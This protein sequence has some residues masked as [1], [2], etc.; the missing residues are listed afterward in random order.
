MKSSGQRQ[1]EKWVME[2]LVNQGY[3]A[4]PLH[5]DPPDLIVNR[6]IAVEVRRLNQHYFN[7]GMHQGIKDAN[8]SFYELFQKIILEFPNPDHL[9]SAMISYVMHRPLL[10]AKENKNQIRKTLTE[11]LP[12]IDQSR[13]YTLNRL[14]IE[15]QPWTQTMNQRYF[16]GA[17]H[18]GIK[19]GFILSMASENFP[20]ALKLKE[21]DLLNYKML[22]QECWLAL[23]DEMY[24]WHD[25]RSLQEL[26]DTL[27]IQ[28]DFDKI[29]LF[30]PFK[31]FAFTIL[32]D[33]EGQ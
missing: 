13:N 16:I 17:M 27:K 15:I 25:D 20:I 12:F 30:S 11:H 3:D 23:I 18:D 28:T 6:N 32:H 22:Y 2:S 9:P 31:H 8:Q 10:S 29:L 7:D 33:R 19:G 21:K 24:L 4:V 14:D 1:D 5:P 26:R